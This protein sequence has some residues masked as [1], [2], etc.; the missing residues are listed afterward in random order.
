M[1]TREAGW[2]LF[3][4]FEGADLSCSDCCS[5]VCNKDRTG[6][7]HAME[8]ISDLNISSF[9]FLFITPIFI[10]LSGIILQRC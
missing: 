3:E 2:L 7:K 5:S 9:R 10:F 1:C 4:G 6:A 8:R